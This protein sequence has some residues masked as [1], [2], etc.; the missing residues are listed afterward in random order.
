MIDLLGLFVLDCAVFL[1]V[2]RALS[3]LGSR[4]PAPVRVALGILLT[5]LAM[6]W[7]LWTVPTSWSLLA[8]AAAAAVGS[9]SL[10]GEGLRGLTEALG[11]LR[12]AVYLLSVATLCGLVFL[13][14]PITT[15]LTSPG[16]IG[17]HLD[18]LLSVN[19]RDAMVIVY[20]AA[21][22]YALAVT[23]RMKT[24]LTLMALGGLTLGLV[25]SYALPFGYP[26]MTGL[27]FEQ[28]PISTGSRVLRIF[29]DATIVAAV[30]LA[31]RAVL[32]RYGAR[33]VVVGLLLTNLSL[34][35]AAAVGLFRDDVGGAGGPETAARLPEQPLRFSRTQ[36]NVLILFLDR[37]MGSFVESILQTHPE[38]AERLSGFTWYPRT[39]AAGENSIVGVHPML[40]GYDYL[41]V[42]MNARGKLLRDVSVEA[43]SIL[44]INFSKKGYRVNVVSPRGLGFTMAGDCRFLEM[45]G[46]YCTHIS[47]TV[48]K[49]RAEQMGFPLNDL[50]KSSY[51]DLLVLLASMRGAPYAMKEVLLQKGPWRP[52]L[53][54][55]AGTTFREWAELKALAELSFPQA[56]EPNFNFISNILPH[57][58]YFM[59]EDCLPRQE[60]FKVPLEEARRR[61]HVSLHSLQHAIAARC[62][63]LAVAD[64]FDFLKGA[65]VYDN[66]KIV[67]VSDHG[68]HGAIEDHSTRAVAGGTEDDFFVRTRSVLLV[69]EREASGRLRVSEAFMPNAEV[70]RIVCED[71]GGCVNPYLGNKPIADLGRDD[72][73]FASIVPWQFSQ[74][75]RHS[76]VIE[77]QLALR[78]KDP[79]NAKGWAVIPPPQPAR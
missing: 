73:F 46:V 56:S 43:Y 48:S 44:P 21:A 68:I 79:F 77:E 66:T 1:L 45:D 19:A 28:I 11:G 70:P 63:L 27:R 13:A 47:P 65:G 20:V 75:N 16:E 64:Y 74:Q 10:R 17:I 15:F 37:F 30:G 24:V 62:A 54:H 76:F 8:V 9:L 39:V 40:G 29:V 50:S 31:L 53:D 59:G 3:T 6:L 12:L 32:V 42:E 14:V 33:P 55:S 4:V 38:L 78:G 60:R 41:P 52:F 71:I 57:E 26:M 18:Y 5:F 35:V 34:G 25:Y 22:L 67:I 72:P 51:A 2:F 49:R 7:A 23:S 69:K 58:P 36:P 61:G